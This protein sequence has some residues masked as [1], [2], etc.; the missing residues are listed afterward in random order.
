ML[1]GKNATVTITTVDESRDSH[2]AVIDTPD[3][4]PDPVATVDA[5]IQRNSRAA[6][7]NMLVEG[8]WSAIGRDPDKYRITNVDTGEQW[9]PFKATHRPPIEKLG[10]SEHTLIFAEL[11]GERYKEVVQ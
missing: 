7:W 2:G 1:P 8:D 10:E 9:R 5:S 3:G 11:V 4:N 6:I